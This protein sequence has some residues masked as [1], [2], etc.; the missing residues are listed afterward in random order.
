MYNNFIN[1]Y[2][3]TKMSD[4]NETYRPSAT[5]PIFIEVMYTKIVLLEIIT[6][7][8]TSFIEQTRNYLLL[9]N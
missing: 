5:Y 7:L 4:F 1:T 8:Q 2:I 3:F 6:N 9:W